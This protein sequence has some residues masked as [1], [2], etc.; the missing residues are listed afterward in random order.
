MNGVVFSAVLSAGNSALF[1]ASRTLMALSQEGKAPKLFS[2]LNRAGVPY[3]AILATSFFGCL[4][5][6]GIFLGDGVLF[7]WLINVT[8]ISGILTWLSIA[9]IHIRFRQ[10]FKAQE[11]DLSLLVYQSPFYPVG[12]IVAMILGIL[13]VLG[14]GYAALQQENG[15]IHLFVTYLGIPLFFGLFFGYRY[16]NKT[17]FIPLK[18]INL[19]R[20]C[21]ESLSDSA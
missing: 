5:F 15:Y 21:Y 8:G 10:A 3:F 14:Q 4:S 17:R 19:E 7:L 6:F 16:V 20:D 18:E 2:K 12:P 1:A 13:I 11:K 9:F